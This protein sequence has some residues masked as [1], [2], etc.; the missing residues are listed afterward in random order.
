MIFVF[1]HKKIWFFFLLKYGSFS[2]RFATFFTQSC[3]RLLELAI[4]THFVLFLT[5]FLF[6][7]FQFAGFLIQ[8]S[9][10]LIFF[11][12]CCTLGVYGVPL[13]HTEAV[14]FLVLKN[15]EMHITFDS[16]LLL[17]WCMQT[18][19]ICLQSSDCIPSCKINNGVH[20]HRKWT[21]FCE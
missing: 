20:H 6:N 12:M 10:R 15:I 14:I 3:M 16:D 4:L 8:W 13:Y 5:T 7:P 18:T 2:L 1:S 9:D 17:I 19:G 11:S 21:V